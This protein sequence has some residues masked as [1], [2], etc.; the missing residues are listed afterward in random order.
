[1]E[2]LLVTV[3]VPEEFGRTGERCGHTGIGY[4]MALRWCAEQELDGRSYMYSVEYR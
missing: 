3:V 1:M 2:S 4:A